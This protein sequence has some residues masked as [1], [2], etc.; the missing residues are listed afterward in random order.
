[1]LAPAG[2]LRS[3]LV[4]DGRLIFALPETHIAVKTFVISVGLPRPGEEPTEEPPPCRGLDGDVHC[5]GTQLGALF[6]LRA[7]LGWDGETLAA[8]DP[9]SVEGESPIALWPGA[10][11]PEE[12][13]ESGGPVAESLPV[14]QARRFTCSENGLA[15]ALTDARGR[16]VQ[17]DPNVPE[18]SFRPHDF[19][20]PRE[21]AAAPAIAAAWTGR[22]LVAAWPSAYAVVGDPVDL[23]LVPCRGGRPVF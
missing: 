14:L 23:V 7:V 16:R 21:G 2:P 20:P 5:C 13:E 4:V 11:C 1:V 19:L 9:G 18:A 3:P 12:D 15:I 17:L 6:H 8:L 22:V 10:R